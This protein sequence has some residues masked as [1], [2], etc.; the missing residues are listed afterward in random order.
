MQ[1]RIYKQKRNGTKKEYED[2][3]YE[4]LTGRRE[5]RRE[6]QTY[7][8]RKHLVMSGENQDQI[9]SH[10]ARLVEAMNLGT[11]FARSMPVSIGQ[12][13]GPSSRGFVFVELSI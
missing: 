3:I 8:V 12:A 7:F 2:R 13:K 10:G 4:L 1:G 5:R 11:L 6:D 9:F